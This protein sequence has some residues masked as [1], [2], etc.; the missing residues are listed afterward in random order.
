MAPEDVDERFERLEIKLAWLE[1]FVLQ[2]HEEVLKNKR[3]S[4]SMANELLQTRERLFHLS[5]EL[6]E[7]P[8]QKPPHY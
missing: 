8:N 2:M 7:I 6:E 4:A 1:D 3:Q 5:K